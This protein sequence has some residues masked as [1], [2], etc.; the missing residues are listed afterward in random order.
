[1][2]SDSLAKFQFKNKVCLT[3]HN[4]NSAIFNIK[5]FSATPCCFTRN[6]IETLHAVKSERH[7]IRHRSKSLMCT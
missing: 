6:F 2:V 3:V 7:A 5:G 1:M 4:E